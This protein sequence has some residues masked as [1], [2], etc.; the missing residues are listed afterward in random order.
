[1]SVSSDKQLHLTPTLVSQVTNSTIWV[2]H[3]CQV[4]NSSI[5][6]PNESLKRQTAPSDFVVGLETNSSIW[7]P[8][9]WVS[10]VLVSLSNNTCHCLYVCETIFLHVIDLRYILRIT[11]Y[12]HLD[13]A[14]YFPQLLVTLRIPPSYHNISTTGNTVHNTAY[15]TKQFLLYQKHL[16]YERLV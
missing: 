7:L 4:T 1:M 2:L 10:N 12:S 13:N 8:R 3:E 14:S 9:S 15:C 11:M 16:Q 6:V 5:W